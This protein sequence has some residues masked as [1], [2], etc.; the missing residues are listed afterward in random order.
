[1]VFDPATVID[2][3]TYRQPHQYPAGIQHVLVN[4]RAVIR[5]GEQTEERP[6]RILGRA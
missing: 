3:A 6:G 4:G 2:H 1:V 5:D